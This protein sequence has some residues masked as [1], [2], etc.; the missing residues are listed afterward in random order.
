MLEE[1]LKKVEKIKQEAVERIMQA[2]ENDTELRK[3][4][5]D[6][7]KLN[8]SSL[9]GHIKRLCE[10]EEEY[11]LDE[12]LNGVEKDYF[13]KDH[14]LFLCNHISHHRVNIQKRIPE[15]VEEGNF[16]SELQTNIPLKY[17]KEI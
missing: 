3:V 12:N 7:I 16:K 8:E 15:S 14:Y 10:D 5:L 11:E 4:A 6:E 17:A 13:D 1:Y 9:K 2:T